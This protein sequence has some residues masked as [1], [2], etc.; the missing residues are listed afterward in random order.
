MTAPLAITSSHGQDGAAILTVTGEIDMSNASVLIDALENTQGH[1]VVD[2]SGVEYL[3]SAGL[4]VLF[5]HADRI[6]VIANPNLGPVLVISG[7]ADL[8]TVHG[9]RAEDPGAPKTD[10]T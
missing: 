3:D 10:V 7:L 6:E 4:A 8:T 2:M 9:L 5:G 1:V